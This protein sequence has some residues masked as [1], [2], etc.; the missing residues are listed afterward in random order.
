M[1]D[2]TVT[3]THFDTTRRWGARFEWIGSWVLLSI[4]VNPIA[5]AVKLCLFG[6]CIWFGRIPPKPKVQVLSTKTVTTDGDYS[7]GALVQK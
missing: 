4:S 7:G 2:W 1:T 6:G 5:P 3:T